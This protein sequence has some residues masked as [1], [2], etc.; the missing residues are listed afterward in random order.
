[1]IDNRIKSEA[2]WCRV[3]KC[4]A[5]CCS[6][7]RMIDNRIKSEAVFCSVLQWMRLESDGRNIMHC[8]A[9][10]HNA[11]LCNTLQHTATHRNTPQHTALHYNT[12]QHAAAHYNTP[13][14]P[15]SRHQIMEA[16]LA[17]KLILQNLFTVWIMCESACVCACV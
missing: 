15:Q 13:K 5:V 10:Q 12:L 9:L 6:W 8:N 11:T 16:S 4:V 2:V 14:R 7:T 17:K 3:S 1:M